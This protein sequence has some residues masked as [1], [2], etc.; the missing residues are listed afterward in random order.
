MHTLGS[1]TQTPHA[2]TDAEGR[3]LLVTLVKK[4]LRITFI[5]KQ[6]VVI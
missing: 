1:G 4:K 6:Y 2:D 3:V 5:F